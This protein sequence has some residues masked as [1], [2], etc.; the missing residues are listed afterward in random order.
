M[1]F[2]LSKKEKYFI[3]FEVVPDNFP[4][5]LKE[6]IKQFPPASLQLE[7]GIQTLDPVISKNIYRKLDIEKIQRNLNFL[8][9]ETKAHLHVDLIVGLPGESLEGFGKNLN[10]L[11]ALTKCEIQIGILK[12]LSGT[13][14][15]RHDEIHGIK[16][17]DKPPYDILQNDLIPYNMMQKM[18]RF[19]RFWDLVY[20]SGNFKKSVIYIFENGKVY[21]E[22]FAFSEWIYVQTLST[23]QISLDRLAKLLFDYI[24]IQLH[25]DKNELI[26]VMK[27]DLM[28]VETRKLP[29]FLRFNEL[30]IKTNNKKHNFFNKRQQKHSN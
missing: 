19:A 27:E 26:E 20:N 9:N 14:I 1:D 12:K 3:H 4:S 21:D 22:F 28:V 30:E 15:D 16:Y 23:W 10:K 24:I 5:S 29:K 7:V 8:D 2:F 25:A 18:K 11:Y 17:S 13:S 6:R